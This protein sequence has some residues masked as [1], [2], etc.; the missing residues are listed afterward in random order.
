VVDIS[1]T[2]RDGDRDRVRPRRADAQKNRDRILRAAEE[3]FAVE[4]INVPID[5]VAERAGVGVGTLYRNF[6]TKEALFEAIVMSTLQGLVDRALQAAD[7]PD[8]AGSFFSFLEEFT[9]V[10]VNKRDLRDA[11]DSAGF[12]PKA[13]FASVIADLQGA[14]DVLL[15]RAREAGAVRGDVS[16]AEVVSL[17]SGACKAAEHAGLDSASCFRMT[18]IVCA[19]LRPPAA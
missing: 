9:S 11:L 17:M 15:T 14:V 2:T 4:G 5:V 12:D 18:E 8:P 13:R 6:P 1:E 10:A 7:D 19:G 3:V 16:A